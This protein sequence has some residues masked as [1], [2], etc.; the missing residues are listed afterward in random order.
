MFVKKFINIVMK[1]GFYANNN[2]THFQFHQSVQ[3]VADLNY[4]I[5]AKI[6]NKPCLLASTF[7]NSLPL[8]LK[9]DTKLNI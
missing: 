8:G 1:K 4:L 7:S 9:A 3:F 5:S 6:P 2:G